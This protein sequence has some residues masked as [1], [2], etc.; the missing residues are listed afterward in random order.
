MPKQ[1]ITPLSTTAEIIK[2]IADATLALRTAT[3]KAAV[4]EARQ[5]L[6]TLRQKYRDVAAAAGCK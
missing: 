5:Q 3:T 4:Q 2:D 1:L 6:E